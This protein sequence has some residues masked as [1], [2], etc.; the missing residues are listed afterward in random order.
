MLTVYPDYYKKFNCKKEKCRHNCC[1]GW[2]IDIDDEENI[3][4][5]WSVIVTF[6]CSPCDMYFLTN[7]NINYTPKYVNIFF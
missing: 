6:L 2:E 5:S 7:Y 4:K 3:T 1:V